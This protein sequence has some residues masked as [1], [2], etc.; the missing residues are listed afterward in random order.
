MIKVFLLSFTKDTPLRIPYQGRMLLDTILGV[1]STVQNFPGILTFQGEEETYPLMGEENNG[2]GRTNDKRN[3]KMDKWSDQE[4]LWW[5]VKRLTLSSPTNVVYYS[6]FYA[7]IWLFLQLMIIKIFLYKACRIGLVF[8]YWSTCMVFLF[9]SSFVMQCEA[10]AV[11][12]S[13]VFL[14]RL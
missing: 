9:S 4:N 10:N 12:S 8:K 5:L 11:L 13:Y 2:C 7:Q 1:Y 6:Q 14:L 3:P